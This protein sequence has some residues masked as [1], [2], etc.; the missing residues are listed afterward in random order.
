MKGVV[1]VLSAIVILSGCAGIGKWNARPGAGSRLVGTWERLDIE[2]P[3]YRHIKILSGRHFMWVSYDRITRM[4]VSMGGG[5]YKFD[6]NLYIESL[7][8]GSANLPAEIIGK[9]Q[10][11][12]AKIDGDTWHHEGTLSNGFW[13]REVWKRI[14]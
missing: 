5:T 14:E 3:Q 11:F 9:H 1:L 8:F 12:T 6:G 2:V 13:V 4:V 10:F 7:E